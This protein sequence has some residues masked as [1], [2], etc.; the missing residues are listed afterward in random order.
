MKNI[1]VD[2]STLLSFGAGEVKYD[3]AVQS[4]YINFNLLSEDGKFQEPNYR[5]GSHRLLSTHNRT[6]KRL[7][8]NLTR[9]ICGTKSLAFNFFTMNN[10]F[11]H[12]TQVSFPT[13]T[14][15]RMSCLGINNHHALRNT[16]DLRLACRY[17]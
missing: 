15:N 2:G 1:D 12:C 13:I 8:Y 7:D 17:G 4:S 11:P 9:M 5:H 16:P 6:T 14:G 3:A 10:C